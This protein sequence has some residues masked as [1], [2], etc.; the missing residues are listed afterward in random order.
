VVRSHDPPLRTCIWDKRSTVDEINKRFMRISSKMWITMAIMGDYRG[1]DQSARAG[2]E[3]RCDVHFDRRLDLKQIYTHLRHENY[4]WF[5][6]STTAGSA[7][8]SPESDDRGKSSSPVQIIK[9][10]FLYGGKGRVQLRSRVPSRAPPDLKETVGSISG[11]GLR[12]LAWTAPVGVESRQ[13]SAAVGAYPQNEYKRGWSGCTT[14]Q[15]LS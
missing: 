10:P 14:V 2:L 5:N 9:P 8:R 1:T 11:E 15:I 3:R 7:S 6:K 4:L 13:S 12:C